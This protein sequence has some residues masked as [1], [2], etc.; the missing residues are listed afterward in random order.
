MSKL[1]KIIILLIGVIVC[2]TL[3]VFTFRIAGLIVLIVTW[4]FYISNDML[5]IK[6]LKTFP[7]LILLFIFHWVAMF[8][9]YRLETNFRQPCWSP[10]GKQIAFFMNK[11]LLRYHP[12]FAGLAS[13]LIWSRNYLCTMDYDGGNFK[14]VKEIGKNNGT[15]SWSGTG[16]ILFQQNEGDNKKA[17]FKINPE[18]GEQ[19]KL[20]E[21]D[22]KMYVWP[23]WLSPDGRYLIANYNLSENVQHTLEQGILI[24]N[25]KQKEKLN[26]IVYSTKFDISE[27]YGSY[28]EDVFAY[29]ESV[30]GNKS[31]YRTL[32][33]Y[34][35][36]SGKVEKVKI[37]KDV[38]PRE[39]KLLIGFNMYSYSPDRSMYAE[40]TR[41]WNESDKLITDY[42]IR[43]R[44]SY[45]INIWK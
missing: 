19:E 40:G 29:Y 11:S 17:L 45:L 35:V 30:R 18:N 9:E 23:A 4:G 3:W 39:E 15:T 22:N 28:N 43:D 26:K 25:P 5:S 8:H 36:D 33:K 34:N 2:V 6:V 7:M 13:E 32:V 20:F 16:A 38:L 14:V 10:D 1:P 42:H 37:A 12:G 21:H 44:R 31:D 27:I 24:V 41:I